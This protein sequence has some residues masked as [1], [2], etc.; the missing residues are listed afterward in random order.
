MPPTSGA[1]PE[2]QGTPSSDGRTAPL[3]R[4][5]AR[6]AAASGGLPVDAASGTSPGPAPTAAVVPPGHGRGHR[7]RCRPHPGPTRS[8]RARRP[9]TGAPRRSREPWRAPPRRAG[10]CR[11]MRQP[12]RAPARRR[13]F[14]RP[15]WPW[16]RPPTRCS[17]QPGPTRS[18]RARRP[19]TGAPRRSREPWRAPPRRAGACRSMRQ[20]GRAPAR[21]RPFARPPWPWAGPPT[22]CRQHPGPTRSPGRAVQRRARRAA[23]AN[24]ARAAAASGGLPVDA[25]AGTSPGP[26]PT[27]RS[28][29]L[30]MGEATD[31]MPPTSGAD[32]ESQG[33]PSSDG[34][35]APLP[36][37]VARAAAASGGLP[38][39]AAAG[40]S[41]GPAPTVRSPPWPWAGPPTRCRQHPVP[42]RSPGRAVQRRAHR[43]AP[44]NHGARDAAASG[45]LPI[46]A[47]PGRIPARRRP[48]DRPPWSWARPPRSMQ[49]TSGA[50]P[51]PAFRS[52]PL[53]IGEAAASM[54]PNP[55][56]MPR[57]RM[58]PSRPRRRRSGR[59]APRYSGS[60]MPVRTRCGPMGWDWWRPLGR[61]GHLSSMPLAR[62]PLQPFR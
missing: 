57:T 21:R 49:P 48:F 33:A 3:P 31:A 56:P 4:T 32:P 40:T 58:V 9:A 52:S 44:A 14:G 1:D 18:P 53:G 34:R 43:A 36:R 20:P 54:Q 17:P 46:A 42:T 24:L 55:A 38:V 23:P 12:G 60:C 35:A 16:A 25:A 45:D 27:V 13:P 37:T 30:A 61:T 47:Q 59:S 29:P 7:R 15:P 6:A 5:V 19:A 28:P 10:T 22:R 39:D 26:A 11:S 8:P 2:S 50:D 62:R 51:A 41:P